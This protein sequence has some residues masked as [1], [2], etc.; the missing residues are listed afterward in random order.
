MGIS[1]MTIV[2]SQITEIKIHSL[3]TGTETAA[4]PFG[5]R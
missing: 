5:K 2:A 1:Y 3:I 4:K